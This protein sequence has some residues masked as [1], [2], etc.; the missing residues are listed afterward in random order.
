MSTSTVEQNVS[1][2]IANLRSFYNSLQVMLVEH[3]L[4]RDK[5][6]EST[7]ISNSAKMFLIQHYAACPF[8]WINICQ[9]VPESRSVAG[10]LAVKISL[11]KG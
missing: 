10:I 1:E 2:E 6:Q 5:N 9:E 8:C 4:V 3:R 7:R 11:K